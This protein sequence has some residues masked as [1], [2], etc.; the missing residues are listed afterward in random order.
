MASFASARR[1]ESPALA[2]QFKCW[3]IA[4]R[5]LRD[6]S[7]GVAFGELHNRRLV[8]RRAIDAALAR[9]DM[10]L[11]PTL[12]MTAPELAAPGTSFAELSARTADRLCANTAPLNLSGH[13]AVTVPSGADANGLPVAVQLVGR[14]FDEQTPFR[15]AYEIERT[16]GPFGRGPEQGR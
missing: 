14:P 6:R 1:E 13:P 11:T 3:V 15:A 12:P 9:C 4:E 10:L 5:L 7:R 8:V 2:K 16:L